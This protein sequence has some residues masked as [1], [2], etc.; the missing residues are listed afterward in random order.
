MDYKML[1]STNVQTEQKRQWTEDE[2]M[3]IHELDNIETS[4]VTDLNQILTL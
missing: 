1:A 2:L 4:Q 3:L